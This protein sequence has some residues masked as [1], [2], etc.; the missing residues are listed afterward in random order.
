MPAALTVML[1]PVAPV[2]QVIVPPAEGEV[3]NVVEAPL[4]SNVP[5]LLLIIGADGVLFEDKINQPVSA[6]PQLLV[7]RAK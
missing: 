2:D 6:T 5:A 7:D 3:L 1:L 4:Q